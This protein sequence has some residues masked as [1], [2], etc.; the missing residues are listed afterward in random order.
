MLLACIF[1]LLAVLVANLRD[2]RSVKGSHCNTFRG[3]FGAGD[4]VRLVLADAG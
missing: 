1:A 4:L 2:L 3:L